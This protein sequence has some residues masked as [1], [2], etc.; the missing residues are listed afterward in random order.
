[1]H[2]NLP[3]LGL[4]MI[5]RCVS[6][7]QSEVSENSYFR[8]SI[9]VLPFGRKGASTSNGVENHGHHSGK[10]LSLCPPPF[11]SLHPVV[12]DR[13][14]ST[15]Q[16]GGYMRSASSGICVSSPPRYRIL[17]ALSTDNR[18]VARLNFRAAIDR[19][20]ARAKT[21]SQC[22]PAPESTSHYRCQFP[23]ADNCS[24]PG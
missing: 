19:K 6:I 20:F 16:K 15:I 8:L 2:T 17:R 13:K 1:M 24:A 14:R 18:A 10:L 11:G 5:M 23:G 22:P 4:K 21:V 7:T 3:P 12:V 9:F